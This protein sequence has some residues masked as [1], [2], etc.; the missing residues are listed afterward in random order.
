MLS[1]FFVI[2][3]KIIKENKMCCSRGKKFEDV[4]WNIT[5]NLNIARVSADVLAPKFREKT[6]ITVLEK[7]TDPNM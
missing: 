3:I 4:K 2:F 7:A 5:T 6:F 1:I